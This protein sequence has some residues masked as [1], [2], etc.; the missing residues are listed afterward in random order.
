[1]EQVDQIA[2]WVGLAFCLWL[3]LSWAIRR[4]HVHEPILVTATLSWVVARL[5]I[6]AAP[7]VLH[8]LGSWPRW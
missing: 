7:L 2:V 6:W 1:M 4:F 5:C 3:L 8:E